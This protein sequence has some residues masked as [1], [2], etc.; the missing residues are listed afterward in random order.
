MA[1]DL[2]F[3]AS[4]GRGRLMGS[5]LSRTIARERFLFGPVSC[6][7]GSC[8]SAEIALGAQDFANQESAILLLGVPTTKRGA[9]GDGK[10]L[11]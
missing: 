7:S 4:T 5:P 2:N 6:S 9:C 3:Q 10:F 11:S 1:Q 8:S